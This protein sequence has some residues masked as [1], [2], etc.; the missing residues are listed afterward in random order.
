[1]KQTHYF[2]M[3]TA[4]FKRD[5][6]LEA[7]ADFDVAVIGGGPSGAVSALK[8]A[9]LGFNVLLLEKERNSNKPC[10]GLLTPSCKRVLSESLRKEIPKDVMCSPAILK[11]CY[12]SPEGRKSCGCVSG[13]KLLNL[14]RGLFDKWLRGLA[15]EAGA[16]IWYEADFIRL[17]GLE[18]V[19]I[20]V[21][22]DDQTIRIRA[23]YLIG[24]DGVYSRVRSQL[25]PNAKAE[26]AF[27]LQE[28][29]RAD[30]DFEDCFYV[31]LRGELT[32]AYSYVIPKDAL[33]VVGFFAPKMD[34]ATLK[35]RTDMLKRL[36]RE[37][38]HFK[39]YSLERR[40][41]WAVPYGFI[42]E[43]VG[44]AI[45]VGDAAGFCNTLT[46]EGIKH[47]VE[48]AVAAANSVREAAS[49]KG[50]LASIYREKVREISCFLQRV[51][52]LA[53]SLTDEDRR[54]FVNFMR[55]CS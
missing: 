25:Y 18:P 10:G 35:T 53:T 48:S 46:G 28:Y 32:S 7:C 50:E 11:V 15:A 30:G 43:G 8:C 14:R 1:M 51:H 42:L 4:S 29:W 17:A 20:I 45:L 2:S 33:T 38:F 21:R 12:V 37:E 9:E 36:L 22:R 31:F 41:V 44:N 40:E 6:Y 54:Q 52:Q 3:F 5:D 13:F 47:A 34:Y 19:Q 27:V 49:G 55:A 16:N 39:P 23:R 26:T 24:A